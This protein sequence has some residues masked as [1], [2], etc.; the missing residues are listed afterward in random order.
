MVA[1]CWAKT[2]TDDQWY[3]YIVSPSIPQKG[4]RPGITQIRLTLGAMENEW[5]DVF[6]RVTT[7]D[8]KLIAPGNALAQGLLNHLARF[9]DE[10]PTWHGGSVL[11]SA[12]IEGAYIYPAK[13]FA[14]LPA[15]A[16]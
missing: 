16:N 3:L 11:G 6:E 13:L 2:E 4:A 7:L 10:H 5:A 1:A 8:V 15:G 14:P 9:P 12:F